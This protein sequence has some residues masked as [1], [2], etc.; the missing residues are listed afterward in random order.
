MATLYTKKAHLAM[1]PK[2]GFA[3]RAAYG[4]ATSALIEMHVSSNILGIDTV[5]YAPPPT[6]PLVPNR[7]DLIL[8]ATAILF[9]TLN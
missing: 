7:G 6:N 2:Y 1:R 3:F 8:V 4:V 5:I 9:G